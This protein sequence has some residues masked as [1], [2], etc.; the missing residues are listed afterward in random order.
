[1]MSTRTVGVGV[2]P[3]QAV[4]TI[5]WTG[6]GG[7]AGWLLGRKLGDSRADELFGATIGSGAGM[8]LGFA[9]VPELLKF[10]AGFGKKTHQPQPIEDIS[11]VTTNHYLQSQKIHDEIQPQDEEL[12]ILRSAFNDDLL[13]TLLSPSLERIGYPRFIYIP[14]AERDNYEANRELLITQL[15]DL[16][17]AMQDLT[18]LKQMTQDPIIIT[19]LDK[20]VNDIDVLIGM[21]KDTLQK[22]IRL[23][24][25]LGV[26]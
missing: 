18:K 8:L 1:M 14:D 12:K 20:M 25:Q 23:G 24:I 13:H 22:I 10:F 7:L 6:V 11:S 26:N 21:K 15:N 9:L 4:S 16:S 2:T 5:V 17:K 19:I 3:H